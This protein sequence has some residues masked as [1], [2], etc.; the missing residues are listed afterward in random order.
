[1]PKSSFKFRQYDTIGNV[2]AEA[3]EAFLYECLELP[4]FGGQ[5]ATR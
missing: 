3:D 4:Q 1:M 2:S 5:Q